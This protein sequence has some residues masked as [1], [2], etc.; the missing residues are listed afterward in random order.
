MDKLD[1]LDKLDLHLMKTKR[2][3]Y[4]AKPKALSHLDFGGGGASWRAL[5]SADAV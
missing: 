5:T 1:K 3:R 4:V 2:T